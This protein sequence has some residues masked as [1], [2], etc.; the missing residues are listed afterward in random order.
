MYYKKEVLIHTESLAENISDWTFHSWVYLQICFKELYVSSSS[1]SI[2]FDRAGNDWSYDNQVPLS[3]VTEM[4][5]QQG[6]ELITKL[7]WGSPV[8]KVRRGEHSITIAAYTEPTVSWELANK[9]CRSWNV[10][11]DGK[12]YASLESKDSIININ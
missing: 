2:Y 7:P 12:C 3:I 6:W 4:A 5:I 1:E 9:Q 8:Y 10:M 11:A